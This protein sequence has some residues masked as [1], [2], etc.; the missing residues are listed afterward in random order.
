MAVPVEDGATALGGALRRGA[1][2]RRGRRASSPSWLADG[3]RYAVGAMGGGGARARS[4]GQML[5]LGPAGVLARPRNRQIP[6][7]V[8]AARTRGTRRPTWRSRSRRCSRSRCA[9][10]PTSSSWPGSSPSARCSRSRIAHLSVIVLRFR[11]PDRHAR[12]PGAAQRPRRARA[13]SRSRPR[14]ARCSRARRWVSVV[15]LHEGARIVGGAW[16]VVG[17]GAL[18]RLPP[19]AGQAAD[20][21]ASRSPPRRC[22][23][24]REVEYGSILVPGV[25]RG[26]RRRHRRHGGPAGGRGGRRGRGRGHA[27]GALRV[28]DADVAAARRARPAERVEEANACWRRAKEVGEEYEGVEVATAMVRGPHGRRGDRL[29]G[30][31]AR[32]GGDRAGRRGA[33]RGCAAGRCSAGAAGRATGS[34]GETTRY[35]VEKAPCK[36]ILTAPPATR[37]ARAR[38]RP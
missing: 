29:G 20:A 18:R 38:R 25:R 33:R 23:S 15:V 4:N 10:R 26:A 8:G 16:M 30:Q 9:V 6:S 19:A 12:L 31:A 14:S 35:V 13:R 11:E 1:G 2:A 34:S 28:R 5:G 36:V 7:L 37:T 17:L 22:A 32:G 3:L 21:S 27:R 24:G